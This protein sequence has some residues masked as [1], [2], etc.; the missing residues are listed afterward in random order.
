MSDV[1]IIFGF[2]KR[3]LLAQEVIESYASRHRVVDGFVGGV[4]NLVP[5]PF[6]SNATSAALITAQAPLVY[7]PLSKKI[8]SI[9]LG[10][11]SNENISF[12]HE[13]DLD[14]LQIGKKLAA[15]QNKL[16]ELQNALFGLD[17]LL[18]ISE[19]IMGEVMI[20]NAIAAI[21]F[22]GMAASIAMDSMIAATMTW[23]VGLMTALYCCNFEDWLGTRRETYDIS[24]RFVGPLSIKSGKRVDI[25]A[26]FEKTSR[27][28][29][30]RSKY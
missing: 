2:E 13:S 21:P 4:S 5:I 16:N 9:Y 12:H 6:F 28:L 18:E 14:E 11:L 23:R 3:H 1:E 10:T 7:R 29:Q 25:N 26:V 24:K 15:F 8:A 27:L 30:S 17:F 22:I 19:D 20:G